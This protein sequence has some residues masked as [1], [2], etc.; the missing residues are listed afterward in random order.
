M[1]RDY[2]ESRIREALKLAKGNDTKARAQVM[3]WAAEDQRLLMGLVRPHLTGIVAYAISRVLSR[4][5][6][7]IPEDLPD[8]PQSLDLPPDTFGREILSALSSHDTPVFGH[9]TSA[10]PSRRKKASQSHIDAMKAIASKTKK[11]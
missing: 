11:K 9:E 3:A 1:S 6:N 8:K 4:P 7:E 2:A 5:E 10:P